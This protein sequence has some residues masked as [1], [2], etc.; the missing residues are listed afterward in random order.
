MKIWILPKSNLVNQGVS[1]GL[2]PEIC[3]RICYF[4][5]R[6]K[7]KKAVSPRLTPAWVPAHRNQDFGAHYTALGR[8]V[9]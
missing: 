7:P 4:G 1:L 5:N 3:S 8:Q 6:Y 2:L 9:G